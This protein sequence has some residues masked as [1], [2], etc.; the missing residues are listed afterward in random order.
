MSGIKSP[1]MASIGIVSDL[2]ANVLWPEKV[3]EK[4]REVVAVSDMRQTKDVP[5]LLT[6]TQNKV[7]ETPR[8]TGMSDLLANALWLEKRMQENAQIREFKD[9]ITESQDTPEGNR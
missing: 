1:G 5:T 6:N 3:V 2:I 7:V 8:K 9:D 4:A